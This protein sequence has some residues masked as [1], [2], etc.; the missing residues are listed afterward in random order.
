MF[1]N[2]WLTK[3][4]NHQRSSGEEEVFVQHLGKFPKLLTSL[5]LIN[6]IIRIADSGSS[7]S[8][9]LED[10]KCAWSEC[11]YLE[12]H[13]RHIYSIA[14]HKSFYRGKT[15]LQKLKNQ[16]L[17]DRFT[18]R[19]VYKNEW[20]GLVTRDDAKEACGELIERGW[21]QEESVLPSS[22]GRSHL[23]SDIVFTQ[24]Y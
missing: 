16:K 18:L 22:P 10:V 2:E 8:V 23:Q 13:A 9:T 7:S 1:F 3:F 19:D 20:S 12:G 15:L 4:N 17:K 21:L 24:F 6:C 5:A 14:G 11:E